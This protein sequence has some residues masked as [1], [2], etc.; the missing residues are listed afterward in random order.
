[1]SLSRRHDYNNQRYLDDEERSP[2]NCC[3]VI[4]CGQYSSDEEVEE[5]AYAHLKSFLDDSF[6]DSYGIMDD[7]DDDEDDTHDRYQ[8][9]VAESEKLDSR[10]NRRERIAQ[11][12]RKHRGRRRSAPP[13]PPPPPSRRHRHRRRRHHREEYSDDDY[14]DDDS[15]DENSI[16]DSESSSSYRITKK[17]S[18]VSEDTEMASKD[19]EAESELGLE[20]NSKVDSKS[21]QI[22]PEEQILLT[23]PSIEIVLPEGE[24]LE[25]NAAESMS[26]NRSN[27]SL[28]TVS[29]RV[30]EYST[31]KVNGI[32]SSLRKAK[33]NLQQ[34][35]RGKNA[36]AAAEIAAT[37]EETREL[38]KTTTVPLND[39]YDDGIMLTKITAKIGGL[40]TVTSIDSSFDKAVVQKE[41]SSAMDDTQK[42]PATDDTE[43]AATTN[44]DVNAH[45]KKALQTQNRVIAVVSMKALAAIKVGFHKMKTKV[46]DNT[47]LKNK[48]AKKKSIIPINDTIVDKEEHKEYNKEEKEEEEKKEKVVS[49]EK[50]K[51]SEVVDKRTLLLEKIGE[52]GSL[53]SK[54]ILLLL[55]GGETTEIVHVIPDDGIPSLTRFRVNA[56]GSVSG[57]VKNSKTGPCVN[58]K[59]FRDG[60]KITTFPVKGLKEMGKVVTS[61]NG[62]KYRLAE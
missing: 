59:C 46:T 36:A 61:K 32:K 14:S 50:P 41:A 15:D 20:S 38:Q 23:S 18:S 11:C 9:R 43:K 13:P 44:N 22:P 48:K 12:L 16:S 54:R 52:K 28:Q 53:L 24:V 17:T 42:A 45:D 40:E 35:S 21:E 2:T 62:S 3:V 29:K 19:S 27:P 60:A 58:K 51:K 4:D 56:N 26:E 30:T 10:R 47:I 25:S 39:T 31:R 57:Y 49:T 6:D 34:K 1:M 8:P 55:N 37:G 33:S 5:D 7:D